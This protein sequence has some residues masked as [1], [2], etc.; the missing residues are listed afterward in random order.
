ML[1]YI[2]LSYVI[3]YYIIVYYIDIP[4]YYITLYYIIVAGRHAGKQPGRLASQLCGQES[5]PACSGL[6][7]G[8]CG[9]APYSWRPLEPCEMHLQE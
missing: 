5:A 3:L 7:Q 6:L 2:I 8:L 1:Y 9:C 4:L